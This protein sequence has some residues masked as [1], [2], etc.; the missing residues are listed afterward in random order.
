V[1]APHRRARAA[2]IVADPARDKWTQQVVPVTRHDLRP[3]ARRVGAAWKAVRDRL[4][5]FEALPEGDADRARAMLI[6]DRLFAEGL[7]FNLI[8][9]VRHHAESERRLRMLEEH[10]LTKDLTRLVGDHFMKM[11]RAAHQAYGDALGINKAA[12]PSAAILLGEPLRALADAITGYALQ[13]VALARHDPD[14]REAI[15]LALS[16]I[17]EFRTSLG[18]RVV[19]DVDDEDVA[20][21]DGPQSEAPPITAEDEGP[22]P[23]G[24]E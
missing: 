11:L 1:R 9:S 23:T 19:S 13:L 3:L 7:E 8:S 18:R 16:P 4:V 14:K 10:G 21:D 12:P 15:L 2:L 17:D 22:Q 5:G 24:T 20:N 6:S